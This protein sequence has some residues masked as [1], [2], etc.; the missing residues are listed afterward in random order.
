MHDLGPVLGRDPL[1]RPRDVGGQHDL[2]PARVV[3]RDQAHEQVE[4]GLGRDL[5]GKLVDQDHALRGAV[6][7][8]AEVRPHRLHQPPRLVVKAGRSAARIACSSGSM[9]ECVE[10][11]STRSERSSDGITSA[12]LE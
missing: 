9:N 3:L 7:D 2:A 4:R 8:H 12:A 1:G 11:D 5:A 10:K 6:E